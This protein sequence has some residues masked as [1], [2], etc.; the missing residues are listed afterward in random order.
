MKFKKLILFC[1]VG[2][3][4]CVQYHSPHRNTW[5]SYLAGASCSDMTDSARTAKL[6]IYMGH[7]G[8]IV[9]ANG[10]LSA[11]MQ[12]GDKNNIDNQTLIKY[13]SDLEY[14]LYDALR[15]PGVSVQRAGTDVVI[16]LVRDSI[17]E[18]N[19]PDISSDGADT[20]K[21][22]TKILNKYSATFMEIAGYTD[23]MKNQTAAHALS[24]DMAE[25]IAVYFAQNKISTSRMFIVGRGSARPIAAQNDMGRL[26]NRRVEIRLTPAR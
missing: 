21:I 15:K 1:L 20:L 4:A 12:Y 14:D 8:K 24:L 16:I 5:Q 23:S 17:M 18:L 7:G 13:M 25:R 6:P 19:I 26:T 9:T 3:N 10:E 11:N 22:I 2:L